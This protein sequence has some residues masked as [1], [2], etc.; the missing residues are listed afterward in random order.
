[1]IVS[2][3]VSTNV[4]LLLVSPSN[5]RLKFNSILMKISYMVSRKILTLVTE[6]PE[7]I[8]IQ[9][10]QDFYRF[11]H[12]QRLGLAAVTGSIEPLI[13]IFLLNTMFSGDSGEWAKVSTVLLLIP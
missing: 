13:F 1:M 5:V 9:Y 4:S 8:P 10:R 7:S 12:E 2:C 3:T 11:H 6:K